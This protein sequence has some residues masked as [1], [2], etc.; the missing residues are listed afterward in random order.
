M[1]RHCKFQNVM[2]AE[3]ALFKYIEAYYNRR[4]KHSTIGYRSPA[5]YETE[6]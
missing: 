6:W 4:R 2:E 5:Q 1:I 3:Q